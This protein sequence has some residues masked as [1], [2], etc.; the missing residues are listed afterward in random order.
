MA[1]H[2]RVHVLGQPD[3][4]DLAVYIYGLTDPDGCIRYVGKSS[5]PR[6]RIA[7]HC[8]PT[9]ARN[10]YAWTRWLAATGAKP[11]LVILHTVLPGEDAGPWEL[12][13]VRHFRRHGKLLNCRFYVER[14]TKGTGDAA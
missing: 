4:R 9:A 5:N 3:V 13:Y 11:G 14:A 6:A 10:V 12:H 1:C 8:S 2:G 7:S